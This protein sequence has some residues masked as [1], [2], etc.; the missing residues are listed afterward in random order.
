MVMYK[1]NIKIF[2][3][4]S[5]PELAASVCKSPGLDMGFSTVRTFADSKVSVTLEETVRGVTSIADLF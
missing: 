3:G 2:T 1:D 4:N 5:N